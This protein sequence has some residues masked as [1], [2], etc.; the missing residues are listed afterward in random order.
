VP[1][2]VLGGSFFAF[3]GAWAGGFFGVGAVGGEPAGGDG[4]GVGV[5][6]C[7]LRFEVGWARSDGAAVLVESD[8]GHDSPLVLRP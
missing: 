4:D 5:V 6:V 3:E 1:E 8:C 7:G 2:G